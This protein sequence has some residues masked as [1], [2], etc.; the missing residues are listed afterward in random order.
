MAGDD[1]LLRVLH[2][3]AG[4]DAGGV[5][6]YLFDL[7]TAMHRAGHDVAV[8]GQKGTWHRL[9][10]DAAFDWIEAPLAGGPIALRRSTRALVSC[11]EARTF[12]LVHCHYRKAALVG[13]RMADRLGIPMLFTLHLTHVPMS[14]WRRWLTD[15]GDHTHVASQAARQWLVKNARLDAERI[16]VVRHGVDPK[17]FPQANAATQQ[18]ARIT[19]GIDAAATVGAFVGRFDVPKNENWMLDLAVAAKQRLPRLILILAGA[20]PNEGKLRRRIAQQGLAE[21]VRLL[22]YGDPLVVYRAADALLLPSAREGFSLVCAEAMSVGRCVLRTRTAGTEETIIEGITG[23]SVPI[24]REAFV[25]ASIE[26]LADKSALA[27][28]GVAAAEHV[29]R[30]L[31]FDR[32]FEQ[33]VSL[34]RRLID[35]HDNDG[36]LT[37]RASAGA[38]G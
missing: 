11:A 10:D 3:T 4:S 26:F 29:R 23:R 13:R 38:G 19:L 18:A 12:D 28:M 16:T 36:N 2:L 35:A 1:R 9:F 31:T 22:P 27:L 8:A 32:Q 6:R 30:D 33:T 20:G 34:Y 5:S 17:A 21:R 25:D 15:F 14:G 24:D 37:S 7:C